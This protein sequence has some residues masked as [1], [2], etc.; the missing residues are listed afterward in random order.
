MLGK[1]NPKSFKFVDKKIKD[2]AGNIIEPVDN[3]DFSFRTSLQQENEV[4]SLEIQ[5][6]LFAEWKNTKKMFR[7]ISRLS[8][9]HEAFP[10]IRI[11]VTIVK[12]SHMM[13]G[14]YIAEYTIENADVFAQ[15]E[16]HEIEIEVTQTNEA[17]KTV[18]G[19]LKKTINMFSLVYRNQIIQLELK[20]KI[21]HY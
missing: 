16:K 13:S 3:D 5:E 7:Y 10:Y 12:N 21:L 6:R 19:N 18:L 1:L 20:N 8:L 2:S 17:L 11:D 4:D 15:P 9:V 14:K